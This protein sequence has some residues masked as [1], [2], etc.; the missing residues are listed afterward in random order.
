[1]SRKQI[2]SQRSSR[3][4]V[5]PLLLS[6]AGITS[7]TRESA[8]TSGTLYRVGSFDRG[9]LSRVILSPV[10]VRVPGACGALQRSLVSEHRA[11]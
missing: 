2:R 5:A 7:F 1:M 11:T 3:F 4:L 8:A 10:L 6:S 9:A